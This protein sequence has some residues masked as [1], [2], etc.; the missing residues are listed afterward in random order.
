MTREIE[1]PFQCDYWYNSL[2][3]KH[4]QPQAVSG[5][6]YIINSPCAPHE[7]MTLQKASNGTPPG[8]IETQLLRYQSIEVK[9]VKG[10]ACAELGTY[11]CLLVLGI[12]IRF[13][14]MTN[15]IK[16]FVCEVHRRSSLFIIKLFFVKKKR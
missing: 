6:E 12:V 2:R 10:M 5:G 8:R 14:C 3:R 1:L 13:Q 16:H 11:V 9:R 15:G 7:I 4:S